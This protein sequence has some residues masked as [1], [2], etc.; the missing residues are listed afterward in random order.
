MST[1]TS[2]G[3]QRMFRHSGG[4]MGGARRWRGGALLASVAVLAVGL[5][6]SLASGRATASTAASPAPATACQPEYAGG[7]L[8]ITAT[9]VDPVLDQP[10][11]DEDQLGT[12]T[13]PTTGVTVSFR[14]IHGGFTG[15]AARF[16]FYFPAPDMYRGRF[17]ETTYPTLSQEN[18]AAGCPSV[19]TSA[20]SVAF[21]IS[22]GAYVVSTNN[23]GG[24]PAGG[25]LAPYRANAA[26]AKYSRIVADQMVYHTSARPRGLYLRRQWWRL[27]DGRG[28]G[29]HQ[30][31][32]GRGGAD[33][34]RCS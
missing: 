22:N 34:L 7:P 14:Y 17:F 9:C 21:A 18:A 20:C 23:A 25:A 5:T 10:Y 3:G 6:S 30:R 24:V 13:D 15:S 8:F 26:A 2:I 28:H 31:G 32:V 12:I 27:P 4:R 1:L 19:G 16:A 29:E 33:G 11:I